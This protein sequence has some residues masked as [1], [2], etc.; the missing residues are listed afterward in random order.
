[1]KRSY[2]RHRIRG[3]KRSDAP[4]SL[5]TD[6]SDQGYR[7]GPGRP[8]K[9]YQFKPGQSGNPKGARRK[10]RSIAPDLKALFER[11]LSTKVTLR[12]GEQQKIITNAAAGFEQLANQFAKGDRHARRDLFALAER[13]GVDLL[14]GQGAALE[15]T[16]AAA[17]SAND[18]ALLADYVR[19]LSCSPQLVLPTS[20]AHVNAACRTD[21]VSFVRKSFHL[22][23]PGAIFHMNWHICAIAH[24]LEQVRLGNIKRLIINLPPRSLKSIMCSVAF[25]AFV[26]GHDPTR[27]L[28]V[29]SYSADLAIKHGNDFRA[30]VNSGEYHAIFPGMR[31]SAMK[32]TQTEVVTS[33]NGFRLAISVDG[34]LT[35]RGGD[36]IIVDD[37]IAAL[38]ALSQKSR[39]HVVDFYFN[40]LLSRLDD[41]QNGAIVLVMQRLHEDDLAGVLLRGSDEWTVLSL[42]A[43]AEQDEQIPIGNGQIHPR[44]AGDVLHPER[45][46]REVLEALRAQLG[47]EIFA[48][49][50]QQQ[51]VAPGGA[52]IKR[53]WIRRYD[54]LPTSGL[55]IQS[56]DVA[57]KQGEESD[58]SVCTTWRVH[59]NKYYLIDVLRGRF[60]FPTLR[61]KVFEQAKLHKAAQILIEDAGVGTGL[62][63]ELKTT[64]FSVIAVKPEY[65]KKIRMAIQSGKFEN[66]QVFFPKEAPWLADLEA[67]LFAFPNSRH[68]DQVDSI[69]QTLGHKCRSSWTKESFDGYINLMNALYQDA[70][71]ARLAGRPW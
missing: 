11:A 31:I 32:N 49:Q 62:I 5:N 4:Q 61:M 30:V 15:Q 71:F 42:P 60:D 36:I 55:I 41:K 40:T 2:V 46:P 17:L 54:Q 52:M 58:Y 69:S 26:L 20:M 23:A 18:E 67:E 59:E 70:V 3:R 1:M 38:A 16:V 29:V 64:D 51:P 63:Q 28:I 45:E 27:R 50:Y 35:G 68:D 10:P 25:P 47:A 56:W 33:R 13:L 48:A 53:G 37:P 43:I 6:P 66:G 39:E 44:H 24:C 21:F 8:P 14:A 19:A 12:Q 22:L 9:E 34:A 57:S 7:V 65:D